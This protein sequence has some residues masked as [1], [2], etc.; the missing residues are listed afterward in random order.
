MHGFLQHGS[1]GVR[2]LL[3]NIHITFL[4]VVVNAVWP[5]DLKEIYSL[6]YFLPYKTD[7]QLNYRLGEDEISPEHA[8]MELKFGTGHY[9]T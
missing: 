3:P 2:Y 9:W 8:Q 6:S 5:S 7:L 1:A 4:V